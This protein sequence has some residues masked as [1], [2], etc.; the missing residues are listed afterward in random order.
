MSISEVQRQEP[1]IGE[2][3]PRSGQ[4]N[5]TIAIIKTK[6]KNAKQANKHV[7]LLV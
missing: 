4:H 2:H 3:N 5:K 6:Y 1:G 7:L